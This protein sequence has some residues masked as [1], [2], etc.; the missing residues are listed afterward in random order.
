MK[1]LSPAIRSGPLLALLAIAIAGAPAIAKDTAKQ[2]YTIMGSLNAAAQPTPASGSGLQL[3]SGFSDTRSGP[4][5]QSGD[6]FVLMAKLAYSP[7]V[8]YGDTIFRDGLDP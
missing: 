5:V 3:K 2:R 7:L 1:A 8:C 6:A 4:T